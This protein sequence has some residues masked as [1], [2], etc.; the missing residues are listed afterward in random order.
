MTLTHRL[1]LCL[2]ACALTVPTL[3]AGETVTYKPEV[4]P[5]NSPREKPRADAF[6]ILPGFQVERLYYVPKEKFGSW[7]NITVDPKGRLICTDQEKKGFFR[8]TPP[9]IG[10]NEETKVESLDLKM[11]AAHGLLF[12]FDSLYVTV[13]GGPGGNGLY[14]VP[15]DTSTDKFG[16]PVKLKS[17]AG[18]GEHGPH[19]LRLTPDGK[20]ILLV[21]GNH[22]LPPE[23]FQH[24]RLPKNWSEDHLLPRQWDANGHARG[25]L[26]PGGWIA[27]TDPDGK[28]WEMMTS[29][30]RNTFDFA[31]NADG[32]MFAYDA[33]MEWDM[34]APWY[35]PTRL[36]HATSGS[37]FG[38]RSGTG[39][40]PAYYIDSLPPIIDMGPGSP[41]GVEFG[42]GT[43][44]PAEYQ[45]ALF[46]LDWTF[47][48]IYAM[49][50]EPSGS[51]Y[52]AVKEELLSRTP[53]PLTDAVVGHDGAIYFI[54]GGRNTQSEVFRVT[55]VGKESTERATYTDSRNAD[56]REL[57]HKLEA[58][59]APS[60]SPTR[61]VEFALPYLGHEDRFIR[62]AARIALEHQPAK[63]WQDQV[64]A[65]TKADA[66][67]TG[68]VGLARQGDKS[69]QP[70]LIAALDKL[71][72]KSLPERQQLDMVRTLGLI[73]L[74]M[75]EPS[76]EEAAR[77]ATKFD[78]F[79]PASTDF[80]TRELC[81]LLVYLKSPTVLAKTAELLRKPSV[82]TPQP[83]MSEVIS[84]NKGYG[85]AIQAMLDNAPDQQKVSLLYYIRNAKE[86]WT[87]DERKAFFATIG[88][89][90]H[91]SGGNSYQGFLNNIEK[92]AFDN[93]SDVDRLAIEAGGLRKPFKLP[94][95]P[96]PAGP[97]KDWTMDT[98]LALEEKSK[99]GRSFLNGEKMFKAARCIVC[100]RFY[101]DGGATGP[102]M[103][104][105]A[106]RF[107]FKD[108][109]ESIVLP[110]KVV[111]DQYKASV[112]FTNGGKTYT[113][114][115]VSDTKAGITIL[116]DPEDSTKVVEIKRA[117]IDEVKPSAVSM[118]PEKLLGP[119][120]EDEVA[121]LLAYL[122]SRGDPTDAR[123]KPEPKKNPRKK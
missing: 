63:L 58:F 73:F 85:G 16:E 44:F 56:L 70:K 61:A 96:K 122:L 52:K 51:T 22:T 48:T 91:W 33:D 102:D 114:K 110:S 71:D 87:M 84:R 37:E 13:N 94:P 107:S 53:L 4:M 116:V 57:R 11:T 99:T 65:E 69:L 105:S 98:V 66:L 40:W 35:R 111:S 103:T 119:L 101:G 93:A 47:G 121:D 67:L 27:R 17:I 3:A 43:K 50:L 21:S 36:C 97:G 74:R 81:Q 92:E 39:K 2:I 78:A 9:R 118:M 76:K 83:G 55:Y 30:Y 89:A 42:Y 25:I 80:L 95:L 90:R 20:G 100:H 18:G 5:T 26:A 14:R 28:T 123:F 62:Y 1:L 109:V 115:I 7:V 29:G 32:E 59:H 82:H 60:S 117:D 8:I 15:Y 34:G 88:E 24:S 10:S 6:N 77:L 72:F 38:W 64:L 12:A 31:L 113:G 86:G 106:G 45:K 23:N 75:G 68:V 19:A 46:L 108:M 104:Q 49:H 120:N 79:Y 54:S 112:V 41:V